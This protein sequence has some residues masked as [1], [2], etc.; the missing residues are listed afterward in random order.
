MDVESIDI[1]GRVFRIEKVLSRNRHANAKLSGGSIVVSIPS[2]W[3]SKDK[4]ETFDT[5]LKRAIKAIAEG[6]W[7]PDAHTKLLFTDGQLVSAMGHD[8]HIRFME[9]QRFG[10]RIRGSTIE[11]K[12][13]PGDPRLKEKASR[14]VKR[15]ITDALMPLVTARVRAIN[16]DHFNADIGKV[17]I[18]ETTSIW[19]SC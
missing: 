18:R 3:S 4:E 17:R 5:L 6:R 14:H 19:G 10:S 16:S 7:N 12:V 8:F 1:N 11:V 2:R 9:S 13:V 15:R